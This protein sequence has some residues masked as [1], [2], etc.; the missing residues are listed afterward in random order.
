MYAFFTGCKDQLTPD[1]F[2]RP[3]WLP[4]KL[5]TTVS[6]QENLSMFTECLKRTGLDT[7]LDVSGVWT[8]FAPTDNAMKYYLT[9]HQYD[10]VSDIPS[11]ELERFTEFHI[12]LG[13]W[14]LEQ[15]ETLSAY[16][17]RSDDDGG[18]GSNDYA[19]KRQTMYKEDEEKFW[20]TRKKK[21]E[22][23]VLDSTLADA[24]K[25][26]HVY[27]RKYVPIF[28]DAYF[29]INGLSPEDYSFYFERSYE[30]GN[31]YYAGAK[32]IQADI[33]AENGFVHIVDKVVDPMLNANEL[34]ERELPGE[35][36]KRFL[37]LVYW[38]Y[39]V[40]SPNMNATNRQPEAIRGG[41]PDTLWDLNYTSPPVLF[42]IQNESTGYEGADA[43]L[44][45]VQHNGLVV[46]TDDAFGGFID[47]LLTRISGYPH[48]SDV[49]SLPK[50]VIDLIV[51]PHFSNNPVYPSSKTYKNL[52]QRERSFSQREGDIIRKEFGSNTSF[53]GVDSYTPDRVFTSVTAPVY[54]RPDFSTFRLA[55]QY[56]GIVDELAMHEG[57]ICF[58]P[59][60]DY[61]L[62]VDSSLILNWTNIDDYKYNF[63]EYNRSE[64]SMESLKSS[65]VRYR[66]RSQVG[67]SLPDGSANIEFIPNLE[68]NYIIWN[69]SYHTVS[70]TSSSTIGYNGDVKIRCYP[71]EMD[72]PT[73]NGR[74]WRVNYWFNFNT[75]RL[76]IILKKY[77]L[78]Y[79]LLIQAELYDPD[80][81][82][83]TF[84]DESE[85]FTIFVPSDEA[86][87]NYRADTLNRSD[88]RDLLMYHFL[89]GELI[90]T[91]NKKPSGDY[92]SINK[93]VIPIRT[94]P[95]LI[96]VLDSVGNPRVSIP[97]NQDHT[98]IIASFKSKVT[99]VVH[100]IDSVLIRY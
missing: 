76:R 64:E 65:D 23:I 95:D 31:V 48:W 100:E 42:D 17:W 98:N 81:K 34:L 52:F 61:A 36:Y 20:I 33:F 49:K 57:K 24:Y 69:N 73:D 78:F 29:D 83:F 12:I 54:L 1:L 53:I 3:E 97:E 28:Y 37:E 26:V 79:D 99:S 40:F 77:S 84:L 39:P 67:I 13:P 85:L 74:A 43:N 60:V 55:L 19:F 44:S 46:P 68:G 14:S 15:L 89:D 25:K 62:A 27:S 41:N 96:E 16:G 82:N 92:Y 91:D 51:N 11:D 72:T 50:D 66:I 80:K 35:S 21:Q 30:P 2:T 88:L 9:A 71:I 70:G 10:S 5:Y 22:K 7:I 56:A 75:K 90:F 93:E 38:Y 8:V 45:V 63:R 32:V 4:G 87:L 94:G 18:L 58:F 6:V 59:I 86:L 47:G